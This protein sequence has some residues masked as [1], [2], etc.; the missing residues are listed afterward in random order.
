[1]FS[2]YC[3]DELVYAPNVVDQGFVVLSPMLTK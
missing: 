1:M 2:I 3:D